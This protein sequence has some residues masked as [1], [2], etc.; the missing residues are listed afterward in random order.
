MATLTESILKTYSL[1]QDNM[2]ESLAL[3]LV[4]NYLTN[5]NFGS[6]RIDV[7]KLAVGKKA[8]D[9]E[10]NSDGKLVFYC[11]VKTPKLKLNDQTKM[12]HWTTTASKLRDLIHKAVKQFKDKDTN[13]LKPWVLIFTSD[14]FQLNWSNF[15][16]C[17]Q[18]AVAY[19]S[20]IIKD[21]SNQRFVVG[22]QD[23][24]K[25]VDLFIWCQVNAQAK[26]IYQMVHFVNENAALFEE[27]KAISYRLIPYASEEIMDKNSKKYA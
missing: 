24:I 5:H 26:K 23:D 4:E 15:V 27:T 18:G 21:L 19:N 25:A 20:K 2:T 6:K 3:E 7:K 17:L 16:H 13:H 12:F 1:P 8:P 22:T 10:I 11:E 14:N 9:F